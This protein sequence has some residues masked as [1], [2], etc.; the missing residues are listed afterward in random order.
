VFCLY[1]FAETASAAQKRSDLSD[2]EILIVSALT[3]NVL[4]QH[5]LPGWL[6]LNS[7]NLLLGESL[8]DRWVTMASNPRDNLLP[9]AAKQDPFCTG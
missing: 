2:W 1:A 5:L 4:R 9:E 6:R 8:W 3:I 7:L